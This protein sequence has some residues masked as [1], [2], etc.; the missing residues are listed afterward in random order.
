MINDLREGRLD[1]DVPSHGT[2]IRVKR[3]G[4]LRVAKDDVA[5]ER[6]VAYAARAARV[7]AAAQAAAA[8]EIK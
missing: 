4:G 2:L 7:E 8:V 6:A 5:A 3:Q 1:H